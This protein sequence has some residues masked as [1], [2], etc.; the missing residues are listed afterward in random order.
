[1]AN[2]LI[3]TLT[4]AAFF[5]QNLLGPF[6]LAD[7]F[8]SCLPNMITTTFFGERTEKTSAFSGNVRRLELP[9]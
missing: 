3:L 5:S 8:W 9:G 6:I 4:I 7:I 1:V 2:G